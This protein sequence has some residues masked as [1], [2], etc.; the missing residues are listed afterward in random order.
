M[1]RRGTI[2]GRHSSRPAHLVE[3]SAT[4]SRHASSLSSV[5]LVLIPSRRTSG[6]VT[7]SHR[8]HQLAPEDRDCNLLAFVNNNTAGYLRNLWYLL[9]YTQILGV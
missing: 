1:A 7:C 6:K 8:D 4:S 3:Q 2:G 5:G 9:K